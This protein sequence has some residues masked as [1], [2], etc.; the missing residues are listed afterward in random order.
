[1]TLLRK[2]MKNNEGP[3]FL[4]LLPKVASD[5]LLWLVIP[6]AQINVSIHI[7]TSLIN[8]LVC[9]CFLNIDLAQILCKCISKLFLTFD[10]S[11]ND[12]ALFIPLFVLFASGLLLRRL[13]LCLCMW[14][15]TQV[16]HCPSQGTTSGRTSIIHY[17]RE[18]RSVKLLE[19]RY[20]IAFCYF[21]FF[22]SKVYTQHGA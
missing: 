18:F 14:G 1:M 2:R 3:K 9:V 13:R 4:T 10:G 8:L 20:F 7:L 15:A 21:Y 17:G 19:E 11:G 12:T 6:T 5:Y 22:L 16:I